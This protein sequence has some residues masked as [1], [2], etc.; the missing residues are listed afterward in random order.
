[1]PLK[2]SDGPIKILGIWISAKQMTTRDYNLKK[3]I[4]KA[5]AIL[6]VWEK[7]NLTLIGKIQ[8][9]NTLIIPLFIHRLSIIK[10]PDK[11]FYNTYQ[12]MI[13]KFFWQ[14][15]K[16]KISY[17]RL[18]LDYEQGGLKLLSLDWM[19]KA[20]QSKWV[21][22]DRLRPNG[23]FTEFRKQLVN[24]DAETFWQINIHK[25]DIKKWFD[26]DNFVTDVCQAWSEINYYVP[27]SKENII[28]QVIWFN[29]NLKVNE[30]PLWLKDWYKC[31]LNTVGQLFDKGKPK[32]MEQIWNEFSKRINIIDYYKV[33]KAIPKEWSKILALNLIIKNEMSGYDVVKE[34]V[35]CCSIVYKKLRD[36]KEGYSCRSTWEKILGVEISDK[37]WEGL[38]RNCIRL[39]DSTK[40]RFFQ[41]RVINR[42]LTTNVDIARWDKDVS[43]MCSLCLEKPETIDHLLVKCQKSQQ[44]WSALKRWLDNFC[45]IKFDMDCKEIL[46]GEYK[47]AFPD[48]V[49]T[50]TLITKQYIYARKCLG[51]NLNFLELI[52]QITRYKYIESRSAICTRKLEKHKKNG[53]FTIKYDVKMTQ[54]FIVK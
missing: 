36:K 38:Y 23:L 19:C 41:F 14:G 11:K 22:N 40:L 26:K 25:K 39:T 33:L 20:L 27:K 46:F 50:I 1:M 8:V 28:R 34:N 51:K 30:Q 37:R 31:G 48:L 49:N 21:Q 17:T 32:K 3:T 24:I 7:R 52:K 4:E 5:E 16:A 2:W 10:T 18:T 42:Y 47:D 35:K 15:K 44:L 53:Q 45:F 12:K 54:S 13:R 29:S 6:S 43:P 9:V